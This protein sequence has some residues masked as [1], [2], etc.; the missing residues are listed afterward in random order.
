MFGNSNRLAIGNLEAGL[1]IIQG[2]MGIGSPLTVW[3]QRWLIR[4]PLGLFRP[5]R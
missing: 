3:L 2:G 4:E 5:P 1:P